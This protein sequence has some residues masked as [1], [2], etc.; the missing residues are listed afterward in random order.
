MAMSDLSEKKTRREF[1]R[2][3]LRAA[4]LLAFGGALGGVLSQ[5]QEETVWQIDPEK[6][7]QCGKCATECVLTP[8]AVKCV[9]QYALCGYCDLCFGFYKDQRV[10]D[11]TGAENQRCPTGAL[12]RS[13]V[14]EPYYQYVVNEPRCI[15]CGICVQGCQAYG[16]GSLYLQVRHDR[17]LNCNECRIATACPAQAFVRVPAA[18][19]YILKTKKAYG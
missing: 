13:F 6:C 3:G 4:G 19:P 16:N 7:T 15:G 2:D 1:L 10:D 11:S 17:C 9:H 14:E 12:E 18:K 5:G 8:S